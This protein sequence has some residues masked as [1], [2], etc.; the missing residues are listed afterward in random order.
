MIA[1]LNEHLQHTAECLS[2]LPVRRVERE[3][4]SARW[5]G[6]AGSGRSGSVGAGAGTGLGLGE[7]V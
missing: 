5:S 3:S 4:M 7:V 6:S 2:A 1:S